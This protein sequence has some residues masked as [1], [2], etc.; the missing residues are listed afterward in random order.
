MTEIVTPLQ[1]YVPL[2]QMVEHLTCLSKLVGSPGANPKCYMGNCID[3]GETADR[4]FEPHLK[5]H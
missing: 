4:G 2:A 3:Y 1:L 5:H